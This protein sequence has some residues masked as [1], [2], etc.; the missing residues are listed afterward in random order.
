MI[1]VVQDICVGSGMVLD[2]EIWRNSLEW[3]EFGLD[4]NINAFAIRHIGHLNN[5]E[6]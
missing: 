6:L 5:N 4:L 1:C 3:D 2:E